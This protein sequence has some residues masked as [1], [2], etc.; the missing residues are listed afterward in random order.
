MRRRVGGGCGCFVTGPGP[1]DGLVAMTC[2]GDSGQ[3]CLE[4]EPSASVLGVADLG[5]AWSCWSSPS[6]FSAREVLRRVSSVTA[7]T[8]SDD[9]VGARFPGWRGRPLARAVTLV[10]VVAPVA[11]SS[12]EC[13]LVACPCTW[14][15]IRVCGC[16]GWWRDQDGCLLRRVTW[17][18]TLPAVRGFVGW[19]CAGG[20]AWWA[21]CLGVVGGVSCRVGAGVGG[22]SL[23]EGATIVDK[24]LS[25]QR[26]GVPLRWRVGP[27]PAL[28]P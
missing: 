19:S 24:I 25:C 5:P 26:F 18:W 10:G 6:S 20:A 9:M 28:V 23:E 3:D 12:G 14:S 15:W 13:C 16:V 17:W 11:R 27:G 4:G 8:A 21:R 7:T 22:G 2:D 1:I